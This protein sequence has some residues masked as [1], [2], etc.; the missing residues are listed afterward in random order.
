MKIWA[1]CHISYE[2][3]K[4]L[5]QK[6]DSMAYI[7]PKTPSL[8]YAICGI[9]QMLLSYLASSY[10]STLQTLQTLRTLWLGKTF[11]SHSY[12]EDTK[13]NSVHFRQKQLQKLLHF[14]LYPLT[15]ARARSVVRG[16]DFINHCPVTV[17][18]Q[19]GHQKK[20]RSFK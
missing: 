14:T 11:L 13:R 2:M 5:L 6:R 7:L 18:L 17:K 19:S 10:T 4:Y 1:L 20:V 9:V 3:R 8:K 15:V 12:I 16:P